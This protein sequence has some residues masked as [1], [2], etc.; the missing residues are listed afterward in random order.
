M[1]EG[2]CDTGLVR[3]IDDFPGVSYVRTVFTYV[4]DYPAGHPKDRPN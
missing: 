2:T 1:I 4:A 3:K